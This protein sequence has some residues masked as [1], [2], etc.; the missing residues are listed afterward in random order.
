MEEINPIIQEENT[1]PP[2]TKRPLTFWKGVGYGLVILV[3]QLVVGGIVAAVAMGTSGEEIG[4]NPEE[5]MSSM[6]DWI[7]GIALPVSFLLAVLILLSRR[8]L[9]PNALKGDSSFFLLFFVSSLTVFDAF[10]LRIGSKPDQTDQPP[11]Q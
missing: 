11:F 8:K 3:S 1:P 4:S 7:M 6:M 10:P 2:T 9:H 5:M